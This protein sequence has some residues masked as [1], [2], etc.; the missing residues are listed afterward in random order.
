MQNFALQ[1]V[2]KS[3]E[4][5]KPK[6]FNSCQEYCSFQPLLMQLHLFIQIVEFLNLGCSWVHW[7]KM[8]VNAY[9]CGDGLVEYGLLAQLAGLP[10]SPVELHTDDWV[11]KTN[12]SFLS[13]PICID[14]CSRYLQTMLGSMTSCIPSVG[15]KCMI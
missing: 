8:R 14:L 2:I 13:L 11:H 6:R 10:V 12:A 1:S 15:R 9:A 5:V 7:V 3:F 4:Q